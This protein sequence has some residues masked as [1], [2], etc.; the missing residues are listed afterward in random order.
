MGDRGL[1]VVIG[2]STKGEAFQFTFSI[3]VSAGYTGY[4]PYHYGLFY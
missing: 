4:P 2:K 1:F 3:I